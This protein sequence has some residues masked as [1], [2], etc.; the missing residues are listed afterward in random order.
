MQNYFSSVFNWLKNC[1]SEFGFDLEGYSLRRIYA[2]LAERYLS[3]WFQKYSR[4]LAW[5]I[6]FYDTNKN[7]VEIK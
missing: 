5:P 6:F 1:E 7:K 3:Y 2:F 4:H